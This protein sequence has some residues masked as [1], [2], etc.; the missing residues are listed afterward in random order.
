MFFLLRHSG[1]KPSLCE[2]DAKLEVY[3]RPK[4]DEKGVEALETAREVYHYYINNIVP[5]DKD[6][7]LDFYR[8]ANP[9]ITL[10]DDFGRNLSLESVVTWGQPSRDREAEPYYFPDMVDDINNRKFYI[11]EPEHYVPEPA[12]HLI[13]LYCLGM[14]SRYYPDIWMK[15]I[16]KDVMTAELTDSLLSVIYRR[17]PNLI[18]DQMTQMEHFVHL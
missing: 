5:G 13:L 6:N 12:T 8:R 10:K 9:R 3:L 2:G 1:I 7:L 11:L 14:M 16:D 4:A 17:F 15:S 18:L